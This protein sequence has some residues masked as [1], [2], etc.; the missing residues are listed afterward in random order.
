MQSREFYP[1]SK[2]DEQHADWF[3]G[4][5][6]VGL[7]ATKET[8]KSTRIDRD[9]N[10]ERHRLRRV[11]ELQSYQPLTPLQQSLLGGFVGF[12]R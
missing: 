10:A 11:E 8:A 4:V 3:V 5:S 12:K 2:E 1:L 6:T 7:F 9:N